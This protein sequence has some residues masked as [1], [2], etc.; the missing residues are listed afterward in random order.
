MRSQVGNYL[1]IC[2]ALINAGASTFSEDLFI[3]PFSHLGQN[4]LVYPRGERDDDDIRN[5]K[6]MSK[7]ISLAIREKQR[8]DNLARARGMPS[9][10]YDLQTSIRQNNIRNI[11]KICSSLSPFNVNDCLPDGRTPLLF[12]FELFSKISNSGDFS[13]LGSKHTKAEKYRPCIIELLNRGADPG[14]RLCD[15]YFLLEH[16]IFRLGDADIICSLLEHGADPNASRFPTLKPLSLVLQAE[17][18]EVY[19]GQDL[20]R[21]VKTLLKYGAD[22]N[23]V[24]PNGET[25]FVSYAYYNKDLCKVFLEHGA[26]P[27]SMR[28]DGNPILHGLLGSTRIDAFLTL[29]EFGA[30]V[31]I[32][33]DEGNT[34]L[35]KCA[36]KNNTHDAHMK[37]IFE[38]GGSNACIQNHLGQT[39]LDLAII[40]KKIRLIPILREEQEKCRRNREMAMAMGFHRRLGPNSSMKEL[41]PDI[42]KEIVKHLD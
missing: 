4:T 16:S 15:N 9:M 13:E 22:L 25:A 7:F 5:N 28:A 3:E 27:N 41:E 37:A 30:D 1:D 21:I 12:A 38:H 35:H 29:L 19:F 20:L 36:A 18:Y 10:L 42:L 2:T 26:D 11:Q 6:D 8:R 39:A 14:F 31:N 33:D 24:Q 23:F 34:A 40:N 17:D 32:Q